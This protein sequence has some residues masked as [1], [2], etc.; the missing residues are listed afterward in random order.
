[1][2]SIIRR[3]CIRRRTAMQRSTL[4]E[5]L[6]RLDGHFTDLLPMDALRLNLGEG[7]DPA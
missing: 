5:D 1:M 3:V 6:V 4:F 2:V 7:R